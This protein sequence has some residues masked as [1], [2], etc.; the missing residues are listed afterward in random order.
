VSSTE[1]GTCAHGTPGN[2]FCEGCGRV[3]REDDIATDNCDPRL[4]PERPAY[5]EE[6][7]LHIRVFLTDRRAGG[8]SPHL[9]PLSGVSA[10]LGLDKPPDFTIEEMQDLMFATKMAAI[11]ILR[12]RGRRVKRMPHLRLQPRRRA[13]P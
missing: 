7:I 2:D 3:V 5:A 8:I 4:D 11:K 1:D 9:T 10:D 6:V 12:A 13:K